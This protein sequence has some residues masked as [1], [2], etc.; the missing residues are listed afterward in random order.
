[1]QT[2]HRVADQRCGPAELCDR[3]PEIV[4]EPLGADRMRVGDVAAAMPRCVVRVDLAVPGQPRQLAG[5]GAPSTHQAVHE[6]QR[7]AATP[8]AGQQFGGHDDYM[9]ISDSIQPRAK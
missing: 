7:F 3:V 6:H 4:D 1:M 8:S 5:P 9:P 2:T